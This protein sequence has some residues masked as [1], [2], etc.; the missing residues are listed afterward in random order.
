MDPPVT[1]FLII[2]DVVAVSIFITAVATAVATALSR[3]QRL[4][5]GVSGERRGT[6]L[7]SMDC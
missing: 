6:E 5:V 4:A 7:V 1:V 3:R 2:F